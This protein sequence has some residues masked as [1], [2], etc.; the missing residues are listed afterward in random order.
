MYLGVKSR[1]DDSGMTEEISTVC[2][3]NFE[4]KKVSVVHRRGRRLIS[5]PFLLSNHRKVFGTIL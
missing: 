5:I 3:N 2:R 1:E 4:K